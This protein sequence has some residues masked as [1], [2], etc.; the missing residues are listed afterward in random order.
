[1]EFESRL[2]AA[3]CLHAYTRDVWVWRFSDVLVSVR[4]VRLSG[5]GSTGRRRAFAEHRSYVAI[6]NDTL[7]GDTSAVT[8][9][10]GQFC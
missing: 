8:A 7:I 9:A 2:G 6:Y 4:D 1:L 3:F 10:P 5:A